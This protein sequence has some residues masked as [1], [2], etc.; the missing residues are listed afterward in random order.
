MSSTGYNYCFSC[1][2]GYYNNLT[3]QI[4]CKPCPAGKFQDAPSQTLC[5][6]CAV[7]YYQN[8]ERT[9]SCIACT[10][11]TYA[12]VTGLAT[13]KP[14]PLGT[15][16]DGTGK[17]SCNPCGVGTYSSKTGQIS[18]LGCSTGYYQDETGKEACKPC[19][20]GK[21]QSGVSKTYCDSAPVGYYQDLEGQPTYKPCPAGKYQ[22]ATGQ[23][24]CKNCDAGYSSNSASTSCFK[25]VAGTYAAT[26]GTCTQCPAGTYQPLDGQTSCTKCPA[27]TANPNTKSTSPTVCANC[28]SGYYAP[29]GT[30]NCLPCPAGTYQPDPAKGSCL[31]CDAGTYQDQTGR[32]SCYAC[33]TGMRCPPRSTMYILCSPGTYQPNSKQGDCLNCP[34]GKYT[35]STGQTVCSSCPTGYY[36]NVPGLTAA[37]E[38][39][40]GTFSNV[41]E[42]A[43]CTKC[44]A[45]KYQ[46][47]T[48]STTCSDCVAGKYSTEGSTTCTACPKGSYTNIA[49]QGICT[50]CPLGKQATIEGSTGCTDCLAGYYQDEYY[51]PACKPC[52]AGKVQPSPGKS[53][54]ND[55]TIGYYQDLTAQTTC[56]ICAAGKYAKDPGSPS[57]TNCEP[58]SFN[59]AQGLDSCTKCSI[60]YYQN[61]PGQTLCKICPAGTYG[62]AE[63]MAVCTA[64]PPGSVQP[65]TGKLTCDNCTAGYY[66]P[67]GTATCVICP[68]GTVQPDP[69]K[70]SC[71]DCP[72]GYYQDLT[73]Q[74]TC[75]EC[76]IGYA[77]PNP[78]SSLCDKC[79]IGYFS[80]VT[81]SLNCIPCPAGSYQNQLGKSSCKQCAAGYYA[82]NPGSS[83]CS[84]CPLGKYSEIGW[85]E[86]KYPDPGWV[87]KP[88]RDGQLFKGL[89]ATMADY[90]AHPMS[91]TCY[92]SNFKI[93]KPFTLPCRAAFRPVCCTGA[94]K[95]AGIDCNYAFETES[96][97]DPMKD[98]Y[99]K[100][101][102]FLDQTKC[103]ADGVC[104]DESTWTTNELAVY[105]TTFSEACILAIRDYCIPRYRISLDDVECSVFSTVCGAKIS[106]GRYTVGWTSFEIKLTK[107]IPPI[108]PDCK[109]LLDTTYT[110]QLAEISVDCQRLND[111]GVSFTVGEIKNKFVRIRPAAAFVDTCGL[112]LPQISILMIP[113]SGAFELLA[114]NGTIADI[115]FDVR[116]DSQIID[117]YYEEPIKMQYWEV[118]YDDNIG[119]PEDTVKRFATIGDF[120]RTS[121]TIKQQDLIMGKILNV[122]SKLINAFNEE[123]ISN[124][125]TLEVPIISEGRLFCGPCQI[126]DRSKCFTLNKVCWRDYNDWTLTKPILTE[127]CKRFMVPICYP[128]LLANKNDPQCKD[129]AEFYDLEKMAN[130]PQLIYAT[131]AP[132]GLALIIR[133]SLPIRQNITIDFSTAFD[134][135]TIKWL[136]EPLTCTWKNATDL[137]IDYNP[138]NGEIKEFTVLSGAFFYD[139]NYSAYS[140][141]TTTIQV[142]KPNVTIDID[143]QGLS[144]VSE[145]DNIDVFAIL[146]AKSLYRLIFRWEVT[147]SLPSEDPISIKAKDYFDKYRRYSSFSSIT[148]PSTLIRKNLTIAVKII[149]K[150]ADVYSEEKVFTKVIN[151]HA[152]V[153]KI[154][155]LSKAA[156]ILELDG[157]KLTNVPFEIDNSRC[158]IAADN[159]LDFMSV[160]LKFS[161]TVGS[162]PEGANITTN[163]ELNIAS[164]LNSDFA[165]LSRIYVGANKGFSYFKYYQITATVK[166]KGT[167]DENNDKLIIYMVKPAI[168]AIITSSS[169]IVNVLRDVK[170]SGEETIIP[171]QGQDKV[172]FY[173]KCKGAYPI[174]SGAQCVCPLFIDSA[175]KSKVLTIDKSKIRSFCKYVISLSVSATSPEYKRYSNDQTE[176]LVVEDLTEPIKDKIIEPISQLSKEAYLTFDMPSTANITIDQLECQWSVVEVESLTPGATQKLSVKGEFTYSFFES[177]GI[178]VDE[179]IKAQD[180]TKITPNEYGTPNPL[181]PEAL[182]PTFLTSPNEPV[183]GVDLSSLT[184]FC[185][186]TFGVKVNGMSTPTFQFIKM[187]IPPAPRSRI[188]S[189]TPESGIGFN[190]SFLFTWTMTSTVQIDKAEYQ[191]FTRR[192]PES[193][194]TLSPLSTKISQSNTFTTLLPPG[195]KSCDENV[196][197][198]LR[199]FEYN[200]FVDIKINVQVTEPENPLQEV[201]SEQII[202]MAANNDATIDQKMIVM[203]S[204]SSV[205]VYEKSQESHIVIESIITEF[206]NISK[207][208]TLF[209][210]MQP[211]DQ[212]EFLT[213]STKIL[214]D[215]IVNQ[216]LNFDFLTAKTV[217]AQ[218]DS[219]LTKVQTI[220]GG[221]YIIP[222][223]IA[224]LSGLAD[225][226]TSL[227][228][229]DDFASSIQASMDNLTDMIMKEMVIGSA[230]FLLSSPSLEMAIYKQFLKNGTKQFMNFDTIRGTGVGI[231]P[232]VS[233][234]FRSLIMNSTIKGAPA[235][236]TSVYS[237]MFNP[238][239]NIKKNAN[240]TIESITEGSIPNVKNE[241][242]KKIYDDLK[243]GKLYDTIDTNKLEM[244]LVQFKARP[245][246][247]ALNG[248]EIRAAFSNP[249][250]SLPNGEK[251]FLTIAEPVPLG[252]RIIGLNESKKLLNETEFSLNNLNN[253]MILP[254]YYDHINEIWQNKNCSIT[255]PVTGDK[256][257]K[258][259]CGHIGLNNIDM[260]NPFVITA[261]ITM[262]VIKVIV[263]GNYEQLKNVEALAEWNE[264]T[265]AAYATAGGLALVVALTIFAL[266]LADIK[267]LYEMKLQCLTNQIKPQIP[268]PQT[269]I[270]AKI[271]QFFRKLRTYGMS[272]Y[273][274]RRQKTV[275]SDNSTEKKPLNQ[276]L[277]PMPTEQSLHQTEQSNKNNKIYKAS[278][279]F[280]KLSK[281][282]KQEIVDAYALYNQCI[283]TY[284]EKEF[285]SIM[286]NEFSNNA[287]LNRLTYAYI[288]NRIWQEKMT[289]WTLVRHEHDFLNAI[290]EPELKTPRPSKFLIFVSIIVGELFTTGY[291]YDSTQNVSI[292]DDTYAF[293]GRA[294]IMGL[295]AMTLMIPLK[296][297]INVFMIGPELKEG[298]TRHEVYRAERYAPI[299]KKIGNMFGVAWIVACTYGIVMYMI[300][301][302]GYA[303]NNWMTSFGMS[304]FLQLFVLSQLKVL[305]KSGVG[306]I[307]LSICRTKFMMTTAGVIAGGIVDF[308]LKYL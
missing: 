265:Q 27:G 182:T 205:P 52:P 245:L 266:Y 67:G 147:Y 13:C 38:C 113:A 225:L 164:T 172:V 170:L 79:G 131:F 286:I 217:Q 306:L 137:E 41:Q 146:K 162:R 125:L 135:E 105:P 189:V 61:T 128:I 167:G 145:C 207:Q 39:P 157:T 59:T 258:L 192:C 2:T 15:F 102:P 294:A 302:P 281:N 58:G 31:D 168:K 136:H 93:I 240:I 150:A 179:R 129:F 10:A 284:E 210:T 155:F 90:Y 206:Q 241:T 177:V 280:T 180:N 122:R 276:E 242:V 255:T 5:K 224:F 144:S 187:E 202:K 166:D 249:I 196:E 218:V 213:T 191:L 118:S 183:L 153:P 204:V 82:L 239:K 259:N 117:K 298:M 184:P 163:E 220:Q 65:S 45:G 278:D 132:D 261:D 42:S 57:C 237:T 287:V 25:C 229:D 111:T 158:G 121:I 149:S 49:G 222:S 139:Y 307:L 101:C 299:F 267:A 176:F 33:S 148:I 272:N 124:L 7:G 288:D 253:T 254:L 273:A 243:N 44:P 142:E 104:W 159:Q 201:I 181:T 100:A 169:Y 35:G 30:A 76:A 300:A 152:S 200:Y 246:M 231:S 48:R 56:K 304:V 83:A 77:Q 11:G 197:V 55:C 20:A 89:F 274:K 6:D 91:K 248:S 87:L 26:D 43:S 165:K 252:N 22:D 24:S 18:C 230:G 66:A 74:F 285:E 68:V 80:N 186:Y 171:E 263:Q 236:G 262:N 308:I 143:L 174:Q 295:A 141:D 212:I 234:L 219:Y 23:T 138:E 4:N 303:L 60:G 188:F 208:S 114:I 72:A 75:K 296:I 3:G 270:L 50:S 264:R 244:P 161:V 103:P 277:T 193:N 247:Q 228:K 195:D 227:Q 134:P 112:S 17:T 88:N 70:G 32:T 126:R 98:N 160:D 94:S 12:D 64:C 54:C 19:P 99:C 8:A 96:L 238:Y 223:V 1:E 250:N 232:I 119:V 107:V 36:C 116:I 211:K 268:V 251:I 109:T 81:G 133:F 198:I 178:Y 86:C 190:T 301:F 291:F 271:M 282:E 120:N 275:K 85:T 290:M 97:S 14:C 108:L 256:K 173:W 63:G 292:E 154:K 123:T 279:G 194:N 215:L 21:Y 293:L 106:G 95:K 233:A 46:S 297:F 127:D 209:E 269:G 29:E 257:I 28:V 221:T 84:K 53:S 260:S 203:A 216:Q 130:K 9:S 40:A 175:A 16:Q 78:K 156:Y 151:V 235:I 110:P 34:I 69:V 305:V 115:C 51:Q 37:K 92:N 214:T 289:F 71:I 199:V 283:A 140:V 62:D 226:S 47:A 73:G 185:K